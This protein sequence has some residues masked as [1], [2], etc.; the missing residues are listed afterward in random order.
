VSATLHVPKDVNGILKRVTPETRHPGLQLDRFSEA[1]NQAA[2]KKALQTVCEASRYGGLLANLI[3]RRERYLQSLDTMTWSCATAGPLTLHLSRGSALE[4][5]G[6]CLHPIYGFVYL[7]G[8]GLKGMARAYAETIW[9]PVQDDEKES[10]RQIEDVFGWAP[11]PDRK[12][13][14]GDRNHPAQRRYEHDNPKQPEIK[15]SSGSIIFHDAWP[16]KWP[17]LELDIVNCHHTQYYKGEDAPGDWEDPSM[18][19]FLAIGG[20][21]EFSFAVS[22]RKPENADALVELAKQ[23][24]IGALCHLGAGAKTNAGYGAF[25]P[26]DE[27]IPA[28]VSDRYEVFETTLELVTP[29][30][31]AGAKQ[32]QVDC[33]LR[34]A[35]LRGLLRWWWRTMHAG[36]VDVKTLGQMEAAVWGDTNAGGAVRILIDKRTGWPC[37]LYDK[38]SKSNM[39]PDEKKSSQGILNCDPK[40]TTQGLWYI[41]YGM[42]ERDKGRFYVKPGAKWHIRLTGHKSVYQA[43]DDKGTV[44][45]SPEIPARLVCDQAKA[46]LWLLCHFGGVGSKARKGFGSFLDV[47]V[48]N[49]DLEKCKSVAEAFRTTCGLSATYEENRA[50]SPSLEQIIQPIEIKTPWKD[51]WFTLDQIGFSAQ[52]FAQ[53][54]KHNLKKKALGLPRRIGSPTQGE[55][56]PTGPVGARRDGDVRHASPV[57]YHLAKAKDG[58]LIIRVVAFPA[59]Y[60]PNLSDSRKLL[61]ELLV[62]LQ[63]DLARRTKDLVDKGQQPAR[64]PTAHPTIQPPPGLPA[65]RQTIQAE[66]VEDP[67]GKGRPFAKYGDLVGRIQD[68]TELP[69]D[70]KIG[71]TVRLEVASMSADG[72]E[73]QFRCPTSRTEKS[74]KKKSGRRNDHRR[75][76][77]GKR[78]R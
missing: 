14:I 52:A 67:K 78:G 32:E 27:Q 20:N 63:D 57:H 60:L 46:A 64:Q 37:E 9:L 21:N 4:N 75:A 66:L 70:K 33:D 59:K 51:C 43:R 34:P 28:L 77:R 44:T 30:F 58:T 13:Q 31:L 61:L 69:P 29:A 11:N 53:Q 16:S 42:D 18:V 35:T 56:R 7:P 1:E 72:R 49:F 23:W 55:F 8:S 74:P 73:I 76:R 45:L 22:K 17:Q 15:A 24:L 3:E 71:D 47:E 50:E 10:W 38:R 68:L 40:K 5:A 48:D 36:F 25:K 26:V 2:Q 65:A 19:S 54:Y 62:H 41:S 6:I 39:K 12:K